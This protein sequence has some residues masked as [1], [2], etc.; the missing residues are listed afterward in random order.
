MRGR[1]PA[2]D[3]V[4]LQERDGA[5]GGEG[6]R[7]AVDAEELPSSRQGMRSRRRQAAAVTMAS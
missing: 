4:G 7:G 1:W 3:A 5:V 6:D 2:G